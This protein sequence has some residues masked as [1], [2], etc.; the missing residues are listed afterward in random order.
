M[1]MPRSRD[2]RL[3]AG[4]AGGPAAIGLACLVYLTTTLEGSTTHARV[5]G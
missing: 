3:L 2:L 5:Q 1:T 4:A